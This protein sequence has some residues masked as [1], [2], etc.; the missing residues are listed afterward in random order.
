LH[1][2][3]VEVDGGAIVFAAPGMFGKTTL[4]A[5]FLHRGHRVLAEDLACCRLPAQ[6]PPVVLPG[7]ALLRVRPDVYDLFGDIRGARAVADDP[8]RVHLALEDDLRGT[9]DPVPIAALVLLRRTSPRIHLERAESTSL[10]ADLW[11]VS[12]NLPTDEDRSRCFAGIVDLVDAVPT[13][14]LDRPL[15]FESLPSV[16]DEVIATCR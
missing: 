13:W 3:A 16:L 8:E 9:G 5:A 7:P 14:T 12:F 11:T 4:A 1:A 10:L 2:A 6:G 15:S